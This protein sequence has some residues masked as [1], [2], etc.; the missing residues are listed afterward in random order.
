RVPAD[1]DAICRKCLQKPPR[2]RYA[3]ALE[4]ADDLRRYREGVPVK[5]RDTGVFPRLFKWVARRPAVACLVLLLFLMFVSTLAAYLVGAAQAE[6]A[7]Y[8][9]QAAVQDA[10]RARNEVAAAQALADQAR[11]R[12]QLASYYHDITRAN[13]ALKEN[14]VDD[15]KT[16]LNDL[17]NPT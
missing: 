2:K 6:G 5:A 15:A 11:E 4:L 12:E 13:F 14:R 1:L 10:N 17:Q 16:I 7:A 9:Y 3:T 8:R